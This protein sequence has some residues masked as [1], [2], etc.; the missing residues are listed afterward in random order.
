MSLC[1]YL[2]FSQTLVQNFPTSTW[3]C[4]DYLFCSRGLKTFTVFIYQEKQNR[5][6]IWRRLKGGVTWKK[7][8]ELPVLVL[9]VHTHT[10]R[11]TWYTAENEKH[12][13]WQQQLHSLRLKV[14]LFLFFT[15]DIHVYSGNEKTIGWTVLCHVVNEPQRTQ[16]T[17]FSTVT[18][19]ESEPLSRKRVVTHNFS[20][21]FIF[22]VKQREVCSYK[23]HR[24]VWTSK[25]VDFPKNLLKRSFN[26]RKRLQ[27]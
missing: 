4:C 11:N 1:W 12:L 6:L 23:R 3:T 16:N 25:T 18:Q 22:P 9:N 2:L 15:S 19:Q 21:W 20:M 26:C 10:K 7:K 8:H 17:V 14:C 5:L 27:Y 13:E 24:T